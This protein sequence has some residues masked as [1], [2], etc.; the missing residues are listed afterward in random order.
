[1]VINTAVKPV[2]GSVLRLT[3]AM[4]SS[5]EGQDGSRAVEVQPSS[6]PPSL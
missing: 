2:W 1:M 6:E 3:V 4:R 5:F